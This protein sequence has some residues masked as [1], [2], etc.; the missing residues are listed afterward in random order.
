MDCGRCGQSNVEDSRF[1]RSCGSSLAPAQLER[2]KTATLLFCDL[3]GST[4][5]GERVDAEAMRDFMADYFAAMRESIERHGGTV[6]K[7]IGDAVVGIFGVPVAH[8]DDAIRAARASLEMQS[9]AS[10]L[11]ARATEAFGSAVTVRIG[12]NTGRVVANV[13]G[14]DQALVTGDAVNT[15]AR[16]EQLAPP[17]TILLGPTTWRLTRDAVVT[18]SGTAVVAKGKADPVTAYRLMGLRPTEPRERRRPGSAFVGREAELARLNDALKRCVERKRAE[19][20]AVVGEAGVGKSRL[21]SEFLSSTSLQARVARGRCLSY[22][23]GATYWALAEAIRDAAAIRDD[24]D[25]DEALAKLNAV[26]PASGAAVSHVARAIGLLDGTSSSAEILW[27]VK[28]LFAAFAAEDPLIVVIDDLHW[29]EPALIALLD[30]AAD[31]IE[32]AVLIVA[33][34]RS[35]ILDGWADPATVVHLE[36]LSPSMTTD[37]VRGLLGDLA[38][39]DVVDRLLASAEGNPLFV[40]ELTER[41]IETGGIVRSGGTW[42]ATRSI[43]TVPIPPTIDALLDARLDVLGEEERRP[44]ECGSVEGQVFH[45]GAVAELLEGA[46]EQLGA[47]L[48]RLIERDILQ[49]TDSEFASENAFTFRHLLIRDAVYRGAP[50]KARAGWHA[51]FADWLSEMVEGRL[52]E[53]EEIIAFHLEQAHRLWGELGRHV[54]ETH[55]VGRRAA[56]HLSAAAT[57]AHERGDVSGAVTLLTRARAVLEPADPA[58][59]ILLVDL[60]VLRRED[61]DLEGASDLLRLASEA[62]DLAGDRGAGAIAR[63]EL[64]DLRGDL[65]PLRALEPAAEME[66]AAET[67][68]ELGDES[69]LV[70]VLILLAGAEFFRGRVR[71]AEELL[72]SASEAVERS[73]Q[74][75]MRARIAW[76]LASASDFGA[77]PTSEGLRRVDA[78]LAQAVDLPRMTA[79]L[80]LLRAILLAMRGEFRS[81]VADADRGAVQLREL[82]ENEFTVQIIA[83]SRWRIAQQSDDPEA[84]ERALRECY[85]ALEERHN[86][87]HLS[88]IAWRLG[89]VL[90]RQGHPGEA[91]E[92]IEEGRRLGAANDTDVQVGWRIA[93]AR[94]LR[95]LKREGGDVLLEEAVRIAEQTDYVNHTADAL[96]ASAEEHRDRGRGEAARAAA[97][98]ALALYER[99]ESLVM[100][101]RASAFLEGTRSSDSRDLRPR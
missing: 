37:L 100:A 59:P 1:C 61:R 21:I 22:G 32:A 52:A 56:G 83:E 43:G 64:A 57:R 66:E 4:E 93:M 26:M 28:K 55:A 25:P 73:G 45:E 85:Q 16:L 8:E 71:Y 29:S 82:G 50:K 18:E 72:E 79:E 65:E 19:V 94:V 12:I 33:L 81:A 40:Q 76:S 48:P 91:E 77:A 53:F 38:D 68:R 92:L 46:A 98:R 39:A 96:L 89:D 95:A 27:S 35:E 34:A 15:A 101:Q 69:G 5:L 11:S 7:F 14:G 44:L 54:P 78:A 80:M 63:A 10:E 41:L 42:I 67:L 62:A 6:E 88:S 24:D 87:G 23:S 84:E 31:G 49:R 70:R 36:P 47:V 20:I 97:V 60:G 75:G 86:L 3:V 30:E 13:G 58:L 99:K 17:G 9:A 2:R 51:R 74:A 90:C